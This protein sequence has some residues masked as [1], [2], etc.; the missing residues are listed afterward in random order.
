MAAQPPAEFLK[1]K[2]L[3]ELPDPIPDLNNASQWVSFE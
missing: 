2:T 1:S 3:N